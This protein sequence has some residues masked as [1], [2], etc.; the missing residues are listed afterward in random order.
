MDNS[1][2]VTKKQMKERG[3]SKELKDLFSRFSHPLI[4]DNV[5]EILEREVTAYGNSCHIPVPSKHLGKR[6][7]VIILNDK[8]HIV[9]EV[10]TEKQEPTEHIVTELNEEAKK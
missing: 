3:A 7:K 4:P 1:V 9:T 8:N 6:V 2:K 5:D 10:V